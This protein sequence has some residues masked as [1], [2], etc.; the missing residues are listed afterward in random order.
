METDAR[1]SRSEKANR[2]AGKVFAVGFLI[3]PSETLET[4]P[5]EVIYD[6]ARCLTVDS[7][8]RPLV[9]LGP[10]GETHT[11][12]EVRGEHDDRDEDPSTFTAVKSEGWDRQY[13]GADER[14]PWAGTTTVTKSLGESSDADDLAARSQPALGTRTQVRREGEDLEPW[15]GTVTGTRVASEHGDQD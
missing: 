3:E 15:A 12:T 6:E 13:S 1:N 4:D 11:L 14:L 5:V 8:G 2:N 7:S 10:V 9:E